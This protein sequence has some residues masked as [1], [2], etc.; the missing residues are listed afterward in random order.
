[1]GGERIQDCSAGVEMIVD[2]RAGW[3]LRVPGSQE[4]EEVVE[5]AEEEVFWD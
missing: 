3:C 1:M 2:G 5:E 4:Q